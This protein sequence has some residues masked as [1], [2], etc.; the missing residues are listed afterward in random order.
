MQGPAGKFFKFYFGDS[1]LILSLVLANAP[2]DV[3]DL[4]VGSNVCSETIGT[5]A[6]TIRIIA[7]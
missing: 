1:F 6:M 5:L 3:D 4:K 7:D 2:A